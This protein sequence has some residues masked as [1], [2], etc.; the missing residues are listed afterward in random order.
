MQLKVENIENELDM[1][2]ESL[3][4]DIHKFRDDLRLQLNKYKQ[5]FGK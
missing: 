4:E 1:K 3:I 5:D 2:V